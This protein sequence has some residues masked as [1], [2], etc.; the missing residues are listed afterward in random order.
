MTIGLI[1][2]MHEEIAS[3]LR[4]M[5]T[6]G[7]VQRI[8]MRDYYTG[9][10]CGQD[11]VIVLARLGKV[12]AAATT[13]T[14]IR[15]F[16]VGS[17]AFTGLAGGLAEGVEVGDIVVAD[18]LIQHDLDVRPFWPRHEVPLLGQAEFITSSDLR[19]RLEN[20]VRIFLDEDFERSIDATARARFRIKKPTLHVGMIA[21]GDQFIGGADTVSSLR[22]LLPTALCVEMEGAAVAQVCHEY[23]IP[24]VIM[25]TISDRADD[26]AHV[27]FSA[28]LREVASHYSAGVVERFLEMS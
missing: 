4:H 6:H 5:D 25:R 12:A 26:T 9:R 23:G 11:V 22:G 8:G 28:F 21:S 20:A 18:R 1:A 7:Q 14:L 19:Q 15:D 24:C 13:V 10:L 17:I 27:D 16:G 2:A 3:L